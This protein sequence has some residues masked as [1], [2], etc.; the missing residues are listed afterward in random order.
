[1]LTAIDTAD[2]HARLVQ[3]SN[4]REV[5]KWVASLATRPEEAGT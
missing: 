3:L 1:L 5:R 4:R 2:A